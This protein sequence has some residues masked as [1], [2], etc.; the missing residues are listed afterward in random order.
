MKP[1]TFAASMLLPCALGLH[2]APVVLEGVVPDELTRQAILARAGEVFGQAQI[3]D[4]LQVGTVATP[5]GWREETLRL[6]APGLRQVR[7]GRLELRALQVHLAGEVADDAVRHELRQALAGG[8]AVPADALRLASGAGATTARTGAAATAMRGV[9]FEPGSARLTVAAQ[10]QLD[11]VAAQLGM[12]PPQL[13]MIVGHTDDA[14]TPDTNLALSLQRAEA[15]R[16]H[17]VDRGIPPQRLQVRGA[18]A[19]EPLADNTTP[20]GRARN[21]RI[22]LRPLD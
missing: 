6:L 20:H 7:G 18:G 8:S 1:A 14:G 19:S 2:A 17:L 22:E 3:E 21:R 12:R 13:L 5:P 16:T 15:V 11:T 4:R 10:R 9:E